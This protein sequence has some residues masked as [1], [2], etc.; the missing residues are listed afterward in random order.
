MNTYLAF[1]RAVNVGGA[2]KIAMADLKLWFAKLGFADAQTVLQSGNALFRG[3][4]EDPAAL[5][6]RLEREAKKQLGLTTEFFIRS[7]AEWEEVI[8]QNPFRDAAE[9]DPSHLVV[10]VLKSEPTA[11]QGKALQAAVKGREISRVRG[12]HAYL[13]YPDGIGRSKL[14]IGVI[15]KQLGTR[16]TGRNWNTVL[17]MAEAAKAL[18]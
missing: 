2:G 7:A 18:R 17:K 12:R 14:T 5:E 8:R 10:T 1:L 11:T 3:R 13:V 16:G 6:L 4:D 15:E 9:S